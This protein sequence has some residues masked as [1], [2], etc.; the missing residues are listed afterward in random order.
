MSYLDAKPYL[1]CLNIKF[2]LWVMLMLCG[3][4]SWGQSKIGIGQWQVHVPY[5]QAR[6]VADAGDK[7]YCAADNGLFY[8]DKEFNSTQT[9][10][11]VDGLREQQIN[12]IRYDAATATLVIA[13]ANTGIDLLQDNRITH[14]DGLRRQQTTGSGSIN[15]I[16]IHNKLAYLSCSFGVAVLDLAKQEIKDTYKDLGANGAVVS[17]NNAAILNDSMYLAT[18]SGVLAAH[19]LKSNLKDFNSWRTLNAGLSAGAIVTSIAVFNNKVYAG[20]AQQGLFILQNK[21]WQSI[22]AATGAKITALQA[23]ADYLAIVSA[24]GIS[25]LNKQGKITQIENK[26]LKQPADAVAGKDNILWVADRGAGL[27]RQSIAN[28]QAVAT[29]APD[30]PYADKVHSI[31]A[32][33]GEVY[34]LSG[35]YSQSYSPFNQTTGFYKYS[36]G[37]WS[38]YNQH[39]YPDQNSFP[40]VRDIVAGTY[41]PATGK[42]YFATYG[43]GLLEWDDLGKYKIYDSGNST[44]L[45]TAANQ[46]LVRVTDLAVDAKGNVWTVN[47]NQQAG[48]P[49][50]HVLK[51]DDKWQAYTIPGTTEGTNLE[52]LVLDDYNYKWLTISRSGN[53]RSGLIVFDEEKKQVKY[54]GAGSGNGGL[55]GGSI[56]SIAKDLNGDIWVGTANG[57]GVFYNTGAV[58]SSQSYEARIPIIEQRPL[59][60][61]Q[62]VQTIAVDGGNRKWIGTEQGLWLFGPDGDELIH[63]FTS[64]NSPLPSDNVLT[65]AVE[66]T[67]G[68]VFIGTDAGMVSY[69]AGATITEGAPDCAMV[70]PNPVQRDFT[71]LIGISGLPNNAQVR[72]TDV[73]GLLVYKTRATGGTA[74]WDARSYNGKRVKAGVYLV[75]SSDEE[76]AQTCISKIAVLE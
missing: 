33:N 41:N 65:I 20:T 7:V 39:L 6:A 23:S 45:G 37:S 70:Y 5:Q 31:V 11:K 16:Y 49:G 71:G 42:L 56:Y 67:S 17:I 18:D 66:H 29:F 25:L 10:T 15:N 51:P 1:R 38:N 14:L 57:V 69:R 47:R 36:N 19:R 64:K 12:T 32:A 63:H 3:P 68:E 26:E 43:N 75:M 22:A 40:K 73:S 30:G 48:A 50:L 76:G 4:I 72:I 8:Y 13:Y 54:L 35:G 9:I 24:T 34:A 62:K 27:V 58:F 53:S 21:S 55:P 2:I 28:S 74:T 59:L 52:H 61:G 44:L 60:A 46:N